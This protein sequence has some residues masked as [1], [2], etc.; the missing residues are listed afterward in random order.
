MISLNLD[1][2]FLFLFVAFVVFFVIKIST[3]TAHINI[4]QTSLNNLAKRVIE[5]EERLKCSQNDTENLSEEKHSPIEDSISIH[6]E[7][8]KEEFSTSE[9]IDITSQ[10]IKDFKPYSIPDHK[11][12]MPESIKTFCANVDTKAQQKQIVEATGIKDETK[13]LAC[14]FSVSSIIPHHSR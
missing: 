1:M 12:L 14:H 9:H 11:N 5:L 2:F 8:K 3:L 13:F 10:H 6:L 7:P 4:L